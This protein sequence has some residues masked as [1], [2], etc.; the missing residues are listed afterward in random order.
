MRLAAER[1]PAGVRPVAEV[2][3]V[4]PVAEVGGRGRWHEAGGMRPMAEVGG[5]RPVAQVGGMSEGVARPE[6]VTN[7]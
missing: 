6:C 1:R 2:G 3:G 4:R 7:S 5:V